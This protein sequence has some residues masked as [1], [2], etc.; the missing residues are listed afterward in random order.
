M[1]AIYAVFIFMHILLLL[2]AASDCCFELNNVRSNGYTCL[3]H[4]IHSVVAQTTSNCSCAQC[5]VISTSARLVFWY[6]LRS[7]QTTIKPSVS[8]PCLLLRMSQ[9]WV[10][11]DACRTVNTRLFRTAD[12]T[13]LGVKADKKMVLKSWTNGPPVNGQQALNYVVPVGLLRGT[14]TGN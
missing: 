7:Y 14:A 2:L 1:L 4:H 6:A 13:W 3:R 11:L 9:C 10:D 8:T 12:W 5:S